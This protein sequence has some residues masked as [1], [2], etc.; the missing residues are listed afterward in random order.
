MKNVLIAYASKHGST[1]EIARAIAC[2]LEGGG[3]AVEVREVSGVES[4]E[5]VDAVV[6]GSAVYIGQWQPA[7]V[8]FIGRHQDGLKRV[9][10]WL[11][12]SGPL[13]DDPFPKEDPPATR[14]LIEKT[15]A[16]G[17]RSFAGRLDR[18]LLGF[19][20]RLISGVVRAPSGDFRRW[21][22]IRA[23]AREIAA[24]LAVPEPVV[25][26]VPPGSP[27]TLE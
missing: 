14:E 7:A 2:E 3:L 19:G 13:G 20:E 27:K 9:P 16:R 10:V 22:E 6:V 24:E 25:T 12:S 26:Q 21:P 4:I 11:F 23:W 8:D 15:G 5:Q 17:Y 1:A 18:S